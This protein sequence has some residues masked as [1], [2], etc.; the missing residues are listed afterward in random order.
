MVSL[1]DG[2]Y[3]CCW[4]YWEVGLDE[5]DFGDKNII[6]KD[7]LVCL[8]FVGLIFIGGEVCVCYEEFIY[9]LFINNWFLGK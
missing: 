3:V 2:G 8:C 4:V 9:D 6:V 5:L 7:I 1:S